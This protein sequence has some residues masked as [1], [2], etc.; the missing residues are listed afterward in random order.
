MSTATLAVPSSPSSPIRPDEVYRL[1]E[2]MSRVGWK[3]WAL[4]KARGNGLRVVKTGG[5]YY[6]RGRDFIAYLDKL[7]GTDP[8]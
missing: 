1:R 4:R 6:V 8:I 7:T 5:Q 2:F 3:R